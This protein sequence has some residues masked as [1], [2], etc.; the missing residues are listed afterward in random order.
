M[1]SKTATTIPSFSRVEIRT[2]RQGRFEPCRCRSA[3]THS[4]ASRE[5]PPPRGT[6]E[7][8]V[9]VAHHHRIKRNIDG[10]E[11]VNMQ[12]QL[13]SFY[14]TRATAEGRPDHAANNGALAFIFRGEVDGITRAY[15]PDGKSNSVETSWDIVGP[16]SIRVRDG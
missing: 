16:W 5:Q 13:V 15:R 3:R 9:I 6:D 2:R 12:L 1:T 7:T 10:L 14:R 8:A 11:Q 4:L